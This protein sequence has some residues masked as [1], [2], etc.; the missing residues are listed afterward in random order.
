MSVE[1]R[2]LRPVENLGYAYVTTD[3]VAA[4]VRTFS[5]LPTGLNA[6]GPGVKIVVHFA[7][8][9]HCSPDVPESRTHG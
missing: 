7:A 5:I 2:D 4:I 1:L 6:A 3:S 9:R 8:T